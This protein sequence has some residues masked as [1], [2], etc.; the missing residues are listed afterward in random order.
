MNQQSL[1][2]KIVS[3]LKLHKITIIIATAIALFLAASIIIISLLLR[4]DTPLLG[5]KQSQVQ[6]FPDYLKPSSEIKINQYRYVS[7]CQVLALKAVEE[8]VGNFE[9]DMKI[10][11]EFIDASQTTDFSVR[12]ACNYELGRAANLNINLRVEQYGDERFLQNQLAYGVDTK[13]A[14]QQIE[15]LRQ[16]QID[17]ETSSFLDSL[18]TNNQLFEDRPST[19]TETLFLTGD[20]GSFEVAY[21]K[22][23]AI[24]KLEIR[25]KANRDLVNTASSTDLKRYLSYLSKLSEIVRKNVNNPAL[26]QSPAPTILGD[27]DELG[28]ARLLEPCDIFKRQN[29]ID[30]FGIE[31]QGAVKRSTHKFG[32][33]KIEKIPGIEYADPSIASCDRANDVSGDSRRTISLTLLTLP[34]ESQATAYLSNFFSGVSPTEKREVSTNATKTIFYGDNP[35]ELPTVYFQSG[36]YIGILTTFEDAS[37]SSE[38]K[39]IAAVNAMVDTIAQRSK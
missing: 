1:I 38:D 7:P 28:G 30:I 27:S 4:T 18:A 26:S 10:S 24:Y 8:T 15:Q 9:A 22:N 5:S 11:E 19:P 29:F 12:T 13:N 14:A 2:S 23:N 39:L 25:P 34:D 36:P 32:A 17:S 16:K 35:S 21:G 37:S 33:S 6:Q 3:W 20:D 31:P